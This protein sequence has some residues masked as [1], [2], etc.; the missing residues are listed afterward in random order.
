MSSAP[1]IPL[2]QEDAAGSLRRPLLARP[3]RLLLLCMAASAVS[4]F[5]CSTLRHHLLR[6]GA[7]DLGFFD[8]A[9]YLISQGKTPIS[10]LHGFHV[11]ADHGSVILYPLALLYFIWADPQMLLIAQALALSAG[12][13]PV[14]RLG[15]HAGLSDRL[16]LGVAGAYLMF[17]LV[18]TSNLFDFHPDVFIVP[19]LLFAVLA[20]RE[21]R[22]I[23]FIISIV[24]ALL[25]K[26][27]MGLT[28]AAMGVWLLLFERRRFYGVVATVAGLAWFVFAVKVLI[29]YFGD[30]RSPSGVGYY[31]YLGGS[32][33]E[34]I[35][36][37]IAHP[38]LWMA[39]IFSR[40][41][42]KYILL[43]VV[44]AAWG[45]HYRTLA[46]LLAAVP[47]VMLNIL[48]ENA[49]QR[50]PFFQ[51]SLPVVPFMFVALIL[52]LS[53]QRAWLS[54][55]RGIVAWSVAMLAVGLLARA[56]RVSSAQTFD[57]DTVNHTMAAVKQI[58]PEAKVLTTFE[59]VPHVSRR[60]V[61]Q[62]VGGVGPD[63]PIEDYDYI[64]LSTSHQSM[65]HSDLRVRSVLSQAVMSPVFH[66][67][68]FAPDVFLFKRMPRNMALTALA[69]ADMR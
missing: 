42:A 21:D 44:P 37:F 40:D 6:S 45:L 28:V 62:Y 5:I 49:S 41:A 14:Y 9:V 56:A 38:G 8:Q 43:L 12:A 61:V 48:S 47:A 4:L 53:T 2:Y 33:G 67:E 26:E 39:K 25:C 10:S 69:G 31:S 65:E 24:V 20:A 30:G 36:N 34:I 19:A 51:Y 22:K 1:S 16:S 13:W 64:L 59:T 35:A 57:L 17:P 66:L 52:A 46:P 29:P 32:L 18:L 27:V 63:L 68:Y 54:S 7:F 58:E 23:L 3:L 11:I 15:R 50:S 55:A 60:E